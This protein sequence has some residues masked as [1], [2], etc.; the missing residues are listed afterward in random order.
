LKLCD[1]D[2]ESSMAPQQKRQLQERTPVAD[3]VFVILTIAFFV[4]AL[5]VLKGAE[6]L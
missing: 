6:K 3:T 5:L 1:S 2:V 4:V